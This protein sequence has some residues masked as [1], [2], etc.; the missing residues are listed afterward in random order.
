[1]TKIATIFQLQQ[2]ELVDQGE[3][4]V[5]LAT[6]VPAIM[7]QYRRIETSVKTVLVRQSVATRL[8]RVQKY[9][10]GIKSTSPYAPLMRHYSKF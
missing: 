5:D 3:P 6:I 2:I 10:T 9:L 7:C 8:A 4:L 1:M